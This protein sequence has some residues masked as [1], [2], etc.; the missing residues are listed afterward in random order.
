MNTG[1]IRCQG[2]GWQDALRRSNEGILK[3]LR[4]LAATVRLATHVALSAVAHFST[5]HGQS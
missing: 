2:V 1:L 5:L 3:A 4:R